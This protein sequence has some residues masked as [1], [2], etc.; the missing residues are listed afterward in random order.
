V[1]W[2]ERDFVGTAGIGIAADAANGSRVA[3]GKQ[4]STMAAGGTGAAGRGE[5]GI[6]EGAAG[7]EGEGAVR[8]RGVREPGEDG[9]S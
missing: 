8:A 7:I 4:S 1:R 3:D 9:D 2:R 6:A 5:E